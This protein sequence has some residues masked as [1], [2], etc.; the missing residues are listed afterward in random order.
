MSE[1]VWRGR[2][3]YD[4]RPV[5]ESARV[6][7]RGPNRVRLADR[8]NAFGFRVDVPAADCFASERD[9]LEALCRQAAQDVEAAESALR[10]ARERAVA[11][12]RALATLGGREGSDDG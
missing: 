11:A 9:A 8:V 6:S 10:R 1:R 3:G 5:V 2:F 7:H 12:E 4:G